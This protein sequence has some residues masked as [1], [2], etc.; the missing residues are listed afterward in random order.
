[1]TMQYCAIVPRDSCREVA[2]I[3]AEPPGGGYRRDWSWDGSRP[4]ADG[5][6]MQARKPDG[7]FDH[8]I[9]GLMWED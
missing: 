8:P 3:F 1:M 6:D 2:E 7:S 9:I 4:R 5:D